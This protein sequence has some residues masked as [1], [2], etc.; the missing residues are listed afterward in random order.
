MLMTALDS[1]AGTAPHNSALPDRMICVAAVMP[2]PHDAGMVERKLLDCMFSTCSA[3][4]PA[5]QLLGRLPLSE[6]VSS[7]KRVSADSAL[8]ESGREPVSTF[9]LRYSVCSE[10]TN[11]HAKGSVALM[12]LSRTS[13]ATGSPALQVTP[14]QTLGLHGSEP[15]VQLDR[16]D[17]QA[18]VLPARSWYSATPAL[19][20][21]GGGLGGRGGGGG[22]EGQAVPSPVPV[23]DTTPLVAQAP[24]SE[25]HM[26]ALPLSTRAPRLVMAPGHAEGTVAVSWLLA[27]S[28][29]VACCRAVQATG[30]VPARAL[31]RSV[32]LCS[33]VRLDQEASRG[34]ARAQAHRAGN[35]GRQGKVIHVH[36]LSVHRQTEQA[37]RRLQHE[38]SCN[39]RSAQLRVAP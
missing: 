33:A 1:P 31:L 30:S 11:C 26:A 19:G 5:P 29:R 8:Q 35:T 25:P 20:G 34:P 22:G 28:R 27:R 2:V 16:L 32:R 23:T 36:V 10:G 3:V 6:F 4:M 13:T 21:G 7:S 12:P 14:V 18:P 38:Q 17:G 24:G 39:E 15:D 9:P 37:M